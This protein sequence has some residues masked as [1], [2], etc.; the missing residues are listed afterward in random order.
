[1][2]VKLCLLQMGYDLELQFNV[3]K[4][5]IP[6]DVVF[7]R[8]CLIDFYIQKQL[9]IF[10]RREKKFGDLHDLADSKRHVCNFQQFLPIFLLMVDNYLHDRD[11]L[12]NLEDKFNKL[13]MTRTYNF[14]MIESMRRQTDE[15]LCEIDVQKYDYICI[16]TSDGGA[17][18]AVMAM[19]HIKKSY[20][21]KKIIIGGKS[22]KSYKELI[23]ILTRL[24]LIDTFVDGD[25][26]LALPEL[27]K[28]DELP[29]TIKMTVKNLN[30]LPTPAPGFG[31]FLWNNKNESAN[32]YSSRGCVYN[33][34]F[35]NE[36]IYSFR[37]ISAERLAENIERTVKCYDT[38]RI[39]VSDNLICPSKKYIETFYK[40]MERM[41][42]V[43]KI[44]LVFIQIPSIAMDEDII[45]MMK[46]LD[47][48]VFIGVESFAQRVLNKMNKGITVERNINIV[49]LCIK[50]K[51]DF[52]M[53]R[54][55]LFPGETMKDYM[56]SIK[57]FSKY[58][59]ETVQSV[60]LNGLA[61][62][63]NTP[64]YE[65]PDKY[66]IE[67]QYFDETIQNI[68]PEVA[69]IV[70]RF[71][72][73]YIDLTDPDDEVYDRKEKILNITNEVFS[74][75]FI[76]KWGKMYGPTK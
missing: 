27:I 57:Y 63:S 26:E 13:G 52:D 40:E 46:K 38:N 66:D 51:L 22:F 59:P 37:C 68:V 19:L 64:I 73:N 4:T 29:K 53:G 49:D 44:I 21:E 34:S 33:C 36:G 7:D 70:K 14:E 41:N 11:I 32:I 75:I 9:D 72:Y 55:V 74:R 67:F 30:K 23:E 1:M 48:R 42:L 10:P 50:H 2:G 25:G 76:K 16:G 12:L 5:Y 43:G 24:N 6:E 71:P 3:L 28:M 17:Y 47:A 61:L 35:C 54:I 56:E 58:L 20:P 69:D 45:K 31:S 60:W 18:N 39:V 15:F 8:Y 62:Y 65:N